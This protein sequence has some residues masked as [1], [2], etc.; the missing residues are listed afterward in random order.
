MRRRFRIL[1]ALA[2]AA[3]CACSGE[4]TTPSSL[5]VAP[6]SLD[7]SADSTDFVPNA[8]RYSNTSVAVAHGR[9]GSASLAARALLGRDNV[10]LLEISTGDLDQPASA[11]GVIDKVQVKVFAPASEHLD[12]TD[13]FKTS[14][15]ASWSY[16]YGGM[17][18]DQRLQV[19]ANVSDIDG[20]RTDVVTVDAYVKWRPDLHPGAIGAPAQALVNTPVNVVVPVHEL[21]GDVGAS[22]DCVLYADGVAVD[23]I[24][25]LWVDR[26]D[27]VS[28]VFRT[29]F[30]TPGVK[31]LEARIENVKPADYDD[32]N[33]SAFATIEI[34]DPVASFHGVASA[35]NE[36]IGTERASGRASVYPK[37]D[38]LT[39]STRR[40]VRTLVDAALEYPHLGLV[41]VTV[42]RE[43]DGVA[44][45]T[46]VAQLDVTD[47][48][49]VRVTRGQLFTLCGTAPGRYQLY[50]STTQGTAAY[51][52]LESMTQWN[53]RQYVYTSTQLPPDAPPQPER[54][55]S[56]LTLHVSIAADGRVIDPAPA[57]PL[58][59]FD[60]TTSIPYSCSAGACTGTRQVDYGV[61]GQVS[62]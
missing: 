58:V 8:I 6:P 47:G 54:W 5:V 37:V 15:G 10:A 45:G 56:S 17:L 43:S 22:A 28:C 42:S 34:L 13:V 32:S 46:T 18:R 49:A 33:N 1:P 12:G 20:N 7:R 60:L 35:S 9:S 4:L 39:S 3:I 26:G 59:P 16:P 48:C 53:G 61:R 62:F 14:G 19:Q 2:L 38:Y 51:W 30:A 29:T 23:R 36:V 55:G 44:F 31:H 27:V 40:T 57:I 24:E 25:N 11:T 50:W 52:S 21:N 41:N